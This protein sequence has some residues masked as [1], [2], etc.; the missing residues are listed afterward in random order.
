MS[1]TSQKHLLV[2][3]SNYDDTASS[4][5]DGTQPLTYYRLGSFK[6]HE[7]LDTASKVGDDL[8]EA[9][10]L[11][12]STYGSF[13]ADDVRA[14]ACSTMSDPASSAAAETYV[15]ATHYDSA[16]SEGDCIDETALDPATTYYRSDAKDD[17]TS[18]TNSSLSEQ[19]SGGAAASVDGSDTTVYARGGWRDHT[20][21]NRITTVRGDRVDVVVGNYKRVV[22]GRVRGD[23]VGPTSYEAAGGHR[24]ERTS[25]DVLQQYA[26][27]QVAET[28]SD[29][30]TYWK[31]VERAKNADCVFRYEGTHAEHHNGPVRRTTIGVDSEST[32]NNPLIVRDYQLN[33][34]KR[35]IDASSFT[36]DTTVHT[37]KDVTKAASASASVD[38][39]SL[40]YSRL[41]GKGSE[42]GFTFSEKLY[43]KNLVDTRMFVGRA[44]LIAGATWKEKRNKGYQFGFRSGTRFD[45]HVGVN[46]RMIYGG[47]TRMY[48]GPYP[49]IRQIFGADLKVQIGLYS[50]MGV[51][52]MFSG[53]PLEQDIR[54]GDLNMHVVRKDNELCQSRSYAAWVKL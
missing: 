10:G 5:D 33:E 18:S 46:I 30:K 21:G 29:G 41:R 17:Y 23:H 20:D 28:D 50:K 1:L 2:L 45:A 38:V 4:T 27:E 51:A 13:F 49:W 22:F 39:N 37:F 54:V 25:S 34:H 42:R 7:A 32:S 44:E 11:S 8:L 31:L 53:P 9:A 12:T 48:I 47:R 40:T 35:T 15:H 43:V 52:H 26:V 6:A 19:L 3:V 14:G 16:H 36:R 24:Q